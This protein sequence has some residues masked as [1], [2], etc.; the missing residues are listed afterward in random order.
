MVRT[1]WTAQRTL[2]GPTYKIEITVEGVHTRALLDHGAQVTIVR[3]QLL[4]KIRNEQGWSLETCHSKELPLKNQPIG[5]TGAELG[6]IGTV[7]L[8]MEIAA[9][10][11]TREI[12]CFVLDSSK[13]LWQGELRDC[14][15]LLGTNALVDS[16]MEV[17]HADGTVIAPSHYKTVES[18]QDDQVRI[19]QLSLAKTIHLMPQQSKWVSATVDIPNV[20]CEKESIGVISPKADTLAGITVTS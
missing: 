7:K 2:I 12:S 4:G 20:T 10:Q 19:L 16:G 14:G 15:I 11:T 13:P 17:T 18:S 8:Q 5:A 3:R 1:N 9:T 6:A